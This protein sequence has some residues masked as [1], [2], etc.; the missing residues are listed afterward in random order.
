MYVGDWPAARARFSPDRAAFIE[1]PE[2]RRVTY[3]QF[4]ERTKALT[5]Y[6][7]RTLKVSKGDRV[8]ILAGDSVEYMEIFFALAKIGALSLPLS[9]GAGP[10]VMKRALQDGQPALLFCDALHE[11]LA[12]KLMDDGLIE[13]IVPMGSGE[14]EREASRAFDAPVEEVINT[15]EDPLSI[16][17]DA[18]TPKDHRGI[19]VSFGMIAW[20]ATNTIL[21]FALQESDCMTLAFPLSSMA[22]L[23]AFTLPLF[24]AGGTVILG[25][26]TG[27]ACGGPGVSHGEKCTF[28]WL[29]PRD[30]LALHKKAFAAP[31]LPPSLRFCAIPSAFES[32]ETHEWLHDSHVPLF[33]LFLLPQAGPGNFV[34]K[35]E[36]EDMGN[37]CIGIPLFHV[38]AMA[39]DLEATPL[40]DGEPGEL[41]IR[42]HHLF[43]GYWNNPSATR[44]SF[45]NGWLK[46]GREAYCDRGLFYLADEG[47]RGTR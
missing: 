10:E 30:L 24:Q 26:E 23:F 43:S 2:G 9:A 22:G 7:Y 28:L 46:T 18:D 17:Y 39:G 33:R 19:I 11:A 25:Q 37:E 3:S 20:N 8:A 5:N 14:Y 1:C 31:Q 40:P 38:D 34:R 29:E 21:A 6:L 15:L 12:K 13:K 41:L 36:P 4:Y 16:F 45:I 42:G 44:A 27:D 47:H 35:L 32:I